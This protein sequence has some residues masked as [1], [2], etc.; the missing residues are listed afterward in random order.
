M[1]KQ[2]VGRNISCALDERVS[3][4]H[5]DES[6]R[7]SVLGLI[8]G[9]MYALNNAVSV[10]MYKVTSYKHKIT[11]EIFFEGVNISTYIRDVI[12]PRNDIEYTRAYKVIET[13]VIMMG[14]AAMARHIQFANM[15]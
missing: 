5:G 10:D 14:D 13:A 3:I 4:G 9:W 11:I 6:L 15:F 1:T 7:R 12:N 8:E 2:P